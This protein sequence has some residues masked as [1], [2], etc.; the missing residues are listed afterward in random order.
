MVINLPIECGA[1]MARVITNSLEFC[2]LDIS[3]RCG[4]Y[5]R[6]VGHCL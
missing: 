6:H 1:N 2:V 3:A 5:R 4:G